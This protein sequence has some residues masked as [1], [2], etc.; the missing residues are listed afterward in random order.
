[1]TVLNQ[2]KPQVLLSDP[3]VVQEFMVTKN[4]LVEKNAALAAAVKNILG[5][6]FIFSVTDET[7]KRKR[8]G[9]AHAFYKDKLIVMLEKLKDY[10]IQTQQLWIER[11]RE[12]KDGSTQI[13]MSREFLHLL[14]KFLLHIVFGANMDSFEVTL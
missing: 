13:D 8:K 12:S 6:G 2:L 11:I 9:I 4:N 1:M 14:E 3:E 5:D 7:W 10:T